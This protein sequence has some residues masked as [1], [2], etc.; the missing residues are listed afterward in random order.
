MARFSVCTA[1]FNDDVSDADALYDCLIKEQ[2]DWEWVVTDDFSE[3][4]SVMEHLL[5]LSRK[6]SRVRYVYQDHKMEFMRNPAPF[7]SGEFVFHID[8]D[9]LFYPGYLSCCERLFDRFP[10]VGIIL[11]GAIFQNQHGQ[12]RNYQVMNDHKAYSFLGRCWRRKIDISFSGIIEDRF[13]TFCNDFFIVKSVCLKSRVLIVPRIYIKYRVFENESGAYSFFGKRI[14]LNNDLHESH[15]RSFDQFIS[16]YDQHK[17][18]Y[19]GLFPFYESLDDLYAMLY[20]I[21]LFESKRIRF[22][23]FSVPD[24]KKALIEDLY[25]DMDISWGESG[26]AGSVNVFDSS[27]KI[28]IE[29]GLKTIVCFSEYSNYEF[30]KENIGP[31]GFISSLERTWLFKG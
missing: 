28:Y 31:H 13:F 11:S 27:K 29:S 20:P 22:V 12:F 9:D 26:D 21:H 6:D 23:G 4:P 10:E 17:Q 2:A 19:E 14:A 1:F 8:S 7:A 16:Y 3:D 18:M 24:W 30:Y 15:K 25:Y 5:G